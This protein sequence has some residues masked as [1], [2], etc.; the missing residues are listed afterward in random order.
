MGT[1]NAVDETTAALWSNF[2][3]PYLASSRTWGSNVLCVC[4]N[5]DSVARRLA[6]A[7]PTPGLVCAACINASLM[8]N[9]SAAAAGLVATVRPTITSNAAFICPIQ[10]Q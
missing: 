8:E 7:S 5:S 2:S 6:E 9:G 1:G 10:D 4:L 3:G